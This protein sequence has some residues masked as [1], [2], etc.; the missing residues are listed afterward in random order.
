[1][2]GD[3]LVALGDHEGAAENARQLPALYP[4]DWKAAHR[5]AGLLARCATL[6]RKG[7]GLDPEKSAEVAQGY[8]DQAVQLLRQAVE[9]GLSDARLLE[10]PALKPLRARPD[11]QDLVKR[12]QRGKA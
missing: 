3:V 4:K 2:L 8:A 6:A 7:G 11:F 5:A 10:E 1:V 12:L 9:N